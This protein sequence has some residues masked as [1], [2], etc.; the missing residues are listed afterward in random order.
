MQDVDLPA[1]QPGPCDLLVDVRAISVDPV[2]SKIRASVSAETGEWKVLGW[3]A[4]G[5]VRAVDNE[6]TLFKVGDRVWY[7]GAVNRSGANSEQHLVNERIAA[8]PPK[9]L[10][11]AEAAAMP[12]TTITAWAWHAVIH[13][14]ENR[15]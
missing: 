12:L 4:M 6:V 14:K 3:D 13:P 11:D 2:D 9:S 8:L 15:C 10:S 5:T 7:A 1:P